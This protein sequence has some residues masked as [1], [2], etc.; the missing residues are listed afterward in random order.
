MIR[1]VITDPTTGATFFDNP[2]PFTTAY[3][4]SYWLWNNQ[5][6]STPGAWT[7]SFF[8]NGALIRKETVIA[9]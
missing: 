4:H 2:L 9:Q 3:R 8:I 1:L 6:P 5:L 7:V